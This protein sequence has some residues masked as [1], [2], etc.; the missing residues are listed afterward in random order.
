M[1]TATER[2][3][4]RIRCFADDLKAEDKQRLD[5]MLADVRYTYQDIAQELTDKGYEVSKSGVCRYA[6]RSRHAQNR[7][8]DLQRRTEVLIR[9]AK[10]GMDLQSGEIATSMLLDMAVQRLA[11]AEDEIDKISLD[12]LARMVNQLQ[13]TTVYKTRYKDNRK[14]AISQLEENIMSRLRELVQEDE[15]LLDRLSGMVT[16]A[17]K[18]EAAKD[19]G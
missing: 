4:Q 17:A 11:S 12:K 10:E 15:G 18:E 14:K 5:D 3:R 9:A 16:E 7:I 2:S 6:S 19:D 13:R 1:P 8:L